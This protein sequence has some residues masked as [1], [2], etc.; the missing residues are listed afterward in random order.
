MPS[1]A[2]APAPDPGPPDD[3][4]HQRRHQVRRPPRHGEAAQVTL[5][6]CAPPVVA[7]AEAPV[8]ARGRARSVT[9]YVYAMV[10]AGAVAVRRSCR[11]VSS[12]PGS[13]ACW[14]GSGDPGRR[15][16]RRRSPES[17]GGACV[18][19]TVRGADPVNHPAGRSRCPVSG[20]LHAA[21]AASPMGMRA[22]VGRW[23]GRQCPVRPGRYD[24]LMSEKG[25]SVS[26]CCRILPA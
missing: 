9:W 24:R 5:I 19:R 22:I 14:T 13:R 15:G 11:S 20:A 23:P 8:P 12:A 3:R 2:R 25:V 17:G 6:I 1:A 18:G 26:C 16:L 10:Y 7:R 21:A 4:P